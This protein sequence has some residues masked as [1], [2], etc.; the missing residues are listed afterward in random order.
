MKIELDLL[1]NLLSMLL[2]ALP[3]GKKAI[4]IKL[5]D[6]DLKLKMMEMGLCEGELIYKQFETLAQGPMAFWVSGYLLSL[7]VDEA[8]LVEI[9][10]VD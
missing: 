3:V 6:S 2:S 1:I 5:S 9:E 10:L 4:I 7:R 8:N